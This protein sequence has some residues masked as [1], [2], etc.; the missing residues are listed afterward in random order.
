MEGGL[1]QEASRAVLQKFF[2]KNIS[3]VRNKRKSLSEQE[4]L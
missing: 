4:E 2:I 1:E 3:D